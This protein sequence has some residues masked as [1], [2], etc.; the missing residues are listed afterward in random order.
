MRL[1]IIGASSEAIHT[2]EKAHELG[3]E[4]VALDG[5][6][7]AKGL[8]S[9]DIPIVVNIT[10]EKATID[11]IEKLGVDWIQTV[12]IGR[13]LTSTGAVN[14]ALGLPGISRKM[15]EYCTDKYLFHEKLHSQNLRDCHCYL[16]RDGKILK[17]G[18]GDFTEISVDDCGLSFPSIAK[19]RFGSGSRGIHFLKNTDDVKSVLSL[20]SGEDYVLEE[21]VEGD[22]YG[23]D[24][25]VLN[26]VMHL[27]LLRKK[28]N[29][30]LP[31]RQAVAYY[32]VSP[33]DEF[34]MQVRDY[35]EKTVAT[36]GLNEC[37]MHGD[38]IRSANG[39]FAVEISSR[40]SGHNLH[41]LFTPLCT[42]I[43]MAY[44][45]M[46]HRMG[47][48]AQTDTQNVRK[49]MIHYFDYEGVVNAVPSLEDVK[50]LLGDRLIKW[51]CN[52]NTG[53]V[54]EYASNGHALMGR[55]YYIVED[56]DESTSKQVADS[57]EIKVM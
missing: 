10:D 29:T 41:N 5:D 43:D 27:V 7:N 47:K 19:P 28:D 36:L 33:S 44:E 12:P 17:G 20:L 46:Q 39:P 8:E 35:L 1:G 30:P 42:G 15:A 53:D 21:C 26:G 13:Y 16:L 9:A 11:V 56:Y 23:V 14:D 48:K 18:C 57:F 49:M 6:A 34:Y 24:A 51:E 2:I 52:I 45:Y 38:I 25:M 50:K 31:N 22:E 32:S 54:L 37:M 55:G 40:P 3:I 4:V